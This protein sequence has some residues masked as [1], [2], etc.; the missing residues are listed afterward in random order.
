MSSQDPDQGGWK[1]R[2]SFLGGIMY[3]PIPVGLIVL[4]VLLLV[5]FLFFYR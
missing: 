5:Y 1:W 3:G 2:Y 4:V